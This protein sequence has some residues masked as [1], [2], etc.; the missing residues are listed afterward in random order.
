MPIPSLVQT[1]GLATGYI[2]GRA[3]GRQSVF[4]LF[5]HGAGFA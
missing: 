3:H 2:A 4:G 1:L 5:R